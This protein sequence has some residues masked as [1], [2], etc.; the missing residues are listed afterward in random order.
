MKPLLCFDLDETLIR[1]NKSH[2]I[3]FNKAFVKNDLKKIP[4][5]K[6]ISALQ[7]EMGKVVVKKLYPKLNDKKINEILKDHD[8]FVINETY[9]YSKQ[10]LSAASTLKKIKKNYNIAI[11]SNCK[12]KEIFALLKGAGIKKSLFNKII[13]KDEVKHGK[14]YPD[15]IF[16][17]EK[18]MHEKADFIIGDSLQD[19]KAAKKARIKVISVLTGNTPKSQIIKANPDYIIKN[20]KGLQSLL[21][22]E[23]E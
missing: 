5:K 11:L 22:E 4:V 20:I 23:K 19:I 18:L 14:P 8:N 2:V 7:G 9:K 10:I 15:E 3:A 12:H 13:G 1:S 21:K 17:A 16:K 6:L